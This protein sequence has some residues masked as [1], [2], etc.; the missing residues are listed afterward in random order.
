LSV[1]KYSLPN[2]NIFCSG[3]ENKAAVII[4]LR[5]KYCKR[6]LLKADVAQLARAADL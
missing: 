4:R 3:F 2:K 1:Q 6:I 5:P